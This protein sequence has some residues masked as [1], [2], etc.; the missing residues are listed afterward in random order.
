MNMVKAVV[1]VRLRSSALAFKLGTAKKVRSSWFLLPIVGQNFPLPYLPAE[2]K[3]GLHCGLKHERIDGERPALLV[4]R[5]RRTIDRV[6]SAN[7]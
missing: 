6:G 3:T 4:G 1:N 7:A 2:E 5:E